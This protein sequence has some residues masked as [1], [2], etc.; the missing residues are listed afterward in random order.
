MSG[1]CQELLGRHQQGSGRF[2]KVSG[3]CWEVS[4]KF[5]EGVNKLQESARKCQEC[6]RK[7]WEDLA[8]IGKVLAKQSAKFNKYES[9]SEVIEQKAVANVTIKSKAEDD[10]DQK[11]ATKKIKVEDVEG[12]NKSLRDCKMLPRVHLIGCQSVKFFLPKDCFK[13]CQKLSF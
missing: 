11:P 8:S 3:R 10:D 4:D 7:C 1:R 12:E 5:L 9:K 13:F 6:A 2:Q